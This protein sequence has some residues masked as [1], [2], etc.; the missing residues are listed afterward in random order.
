MSREPGIKLSPRLYAIGQLVKPGQICADI[1]A[2]HAQLS[3]FLM[4][5]KLT[6]RVIVT[7]I[8]R[9]PY[10]R[11]KKAAESCPWAHL[12][13]LRQGDGLQPLK[14]GEADTVIIAGL[15]G[16]AI[17]DILGSDWE[18][19]ESFKHYIMQPMSRAWVL[20]NTLAE[21]GW[22]IRSEQVIQEEHRFFPVIEATPGENPY[23]LSPLEADLG[24]LVLAAS[25]VENRDYLMEWLKKYRKIRD[26]LSQ[27]NRQE[28]LA[29]VQMKLN[30]LEDIIDGA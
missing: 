24:L 3:I 7:D 5:Q 1:G 11:A 2:D 30:K 29:A 25:P 20:R 18:K 22:P 10:E 13:D 6:P 21:R 4:E 26:G 27:T 28:E 19:S 14:P 17:A 9:G 23:I 15:G 8:A 16:D 12:I